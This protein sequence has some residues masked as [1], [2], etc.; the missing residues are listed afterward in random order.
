LGR[1]APE[2]AAKTGT[3]VARSEVAAQLGGGGTC[4]PLYEIPQPL[5]TT[6]KYLSREIYV[7][8]NTGGA[9]T[10]EKFR[11]G[12][13]PNGRKPASHTRYENGL[14]KRHLSV[15]SLVDPNRVRKPSR[16]K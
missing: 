8:R 7:S 11:Y 13:G 12:K 1:E 6:T 14:K 3:V 16:D 10:Q 4:L 2:T 9:T 15:A 5:P